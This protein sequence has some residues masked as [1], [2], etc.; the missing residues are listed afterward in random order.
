LGEELRKKLSDE[1]GG[2]AKRQGVKQR[3]SSF[4]KSSLLA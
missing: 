4:K 1:D 2:G 3:N